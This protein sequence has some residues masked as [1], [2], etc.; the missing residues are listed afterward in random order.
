MQEF[1][2]RLNPKKNFQ[3]RVFK[4]SGK[5]ALW[6]LWKNT[7]FQLIIS[8]ILPARPKK[9]RDMGCEYHYSMFS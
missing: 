5:L 8:K 9:H 7:K 2:R 4:F 1:L 3:I 6:K